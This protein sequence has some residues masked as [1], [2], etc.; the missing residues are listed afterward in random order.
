MTARSKPAARRKQA[1]G[2]LFRFEH[3]E[4]PLLPWPDFLRRMLMSLGLGVAVVGCSL[5]FGMIG[6]HYCEGL[7]AIDSFLN[8]SMILSGMGPVD[9]MS[10]DAGKLFAGFY[11]LYSGLAVLVTA[12][13]ILAPLVHRLLHRFHI[14]DSEDSSE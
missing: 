5:A 13:L 7:G 12:G 14:D 3:R 9:T 10:T 1:P 4:H 6:Y 2:G 8:A 11:A